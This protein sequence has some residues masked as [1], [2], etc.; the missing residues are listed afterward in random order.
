MAAVYSSLYIIMEPLGGALY[1]PIVMG[2]A[3]VA[4]RLT[5]TYGSVATVGCLSAQ[6]VAWVLQF[7]GHGKFE[8]RAPALLD[9]LAQAFLLGPFFVFLELLFRCGFK[10]QLKQ[11]VDRAIAKSISTWRKQK[12]EETAVKVSQ[13]NSARKANSKTNGKAT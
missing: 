2:M 9:N 3:I 6:L 13:D 7:I 11:R 10:P 12:M 8:G 1:A 4:N 5:A